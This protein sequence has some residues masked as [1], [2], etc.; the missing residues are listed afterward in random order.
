MWCFVVPVL[1][2]TPK[3]IDLSFYYHIEQG[4]LQNFD[5]GG[6]GCSWLVSGTRLEDGEAGLA[7][8]QCSG[9]AAGWRSDFHI[10]GRAS[11]VVGLRAGSLAVVGIG[12]WDQLVGRERYRPRHVESLLRAPG[13]VVLKMETAKEFGAG[14][15]GRTT[16]RACWFCCAAGRSLLGGHLEER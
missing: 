8:S 14:L 10:S 15:W 1:W 3:P 5:V 12:C 7:G 16:V 9:A 6:D 4:D 2:E 11:V 13:V